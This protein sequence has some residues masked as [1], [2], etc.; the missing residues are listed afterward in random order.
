LIQLLHHYPSALEVQ[1]CENVTTG[2]TENGMPY[3]NNQGVKI[4]Y[5]VEGNGEPL[6][7]QHGFTGNLE[8]WDQFGFVQA[9]QPDYQLILLDGRGHGLSDKPHQAEAYRLEARVADIVAV[10]N[11]LHIQKAHFLGY[12]MGGWI[13]F[14]LAKYAPE[15][16]H[17][18]SIGGAHPY[19][20]DRWQAFASVDGTDPDAFISALEL[21]IAETIIPLARP[22]VLA[23]DLVA[24]A[25]SA[26]IRPSLA[27]VLPTMQMPCLL[28][29]GEADSRYSA[30]HRCA[31]Q[32][33]D[34][35]FAVLPELSH[36]EGAVRSDRVLPHVMKFLRKQNLSNLGNL[37]I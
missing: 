33:P 7:L 19:Q 25:I 32:I 21:A 36:V 16:V 14:G 31:Q 4:H 8:H 26:Q 37:G 2:T 10:L 17:S 20:D 3:A 30:V 15:F 11:D 13:G 5:R 27:A 1:W 24:L 28:F 34:V 12:S 29:V 18:L 35:T 23:N 22:Q 6:V 9:L